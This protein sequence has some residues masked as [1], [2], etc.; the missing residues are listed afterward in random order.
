MSDFNIP[1]FIRDNITLPKGYSFSMSD[2]AP[3]LSS[4][5]PYRCCLYHSEEGQGGDVQIA[6]LHWQLPDKGDLTI[7]ITRKGFEMPKQL[8]TNCPKNVISIFEIMA[9]DYDRWL[10]EQ[11]LK[12]LQEAI[13]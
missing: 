6:W 1:N 7:C 13:D 8:L 12:A 2:L 5:G 4:G 10:Q 9:K 11:S 3:G